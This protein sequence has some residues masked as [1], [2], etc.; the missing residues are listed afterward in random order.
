MVSN[1]M[2]GIFSAEFASERGTPLLGE[3]SV[4]QEQRGDGVTVERITV[5][6][7]DGHRMIRKG[8][9]ALLEAELDMEVVGEAGKWSQ[10]GEARR[11]T[12]P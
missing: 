6:L 1:H 10:S 7:A 3:S 12:S 5:L 11:G 8:L 9:R 4:M 2:N